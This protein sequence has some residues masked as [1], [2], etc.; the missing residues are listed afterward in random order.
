[1]RKAMCKFL[2]HAAEWQQQ[3]ALRSAY[4]KNFESCRK[5]ESYEVI[6]PRSRRIHAPRPLGCSWR[7]VC[8]AIGAKKRIRRDSTLPQTA[9]ATRT[10]TVSIWAAAARG[11]ASFRRADAAQVCSHVRFFVVDGPFESSVARTPGPA[12]QIV[13]ER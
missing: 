10:R 11:G 12:R 6:Q 5:K 3:L 2:K 8:I 7:R 4:W 13:S 1:M 9:A